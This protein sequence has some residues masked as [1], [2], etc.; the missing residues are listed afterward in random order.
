MIRCSE[1]GGAVERKHR[2]RYQYSESGLKTVFLQGITVYQCRSCRSRFPEIPNIEGLHAR[3]A[4]A[5]LRKPA[6]LSG[7]EFRFLRKQMRMRAKDLA[8][9][10]G[11]SPVTISR[12]ETDAERIGTAN[13]RLIR[14]VFLCWRLQQGGVIDPRTILQRVQ[15]SLEGIRPT[16]RRVPIELPAEALESAMASK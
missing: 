6:L 1:C 12:W 7:P 5:L 11:V 3:I 10:L 15:S 2:Q 14:L 13:D 4:E 16:R 9:T 8:A